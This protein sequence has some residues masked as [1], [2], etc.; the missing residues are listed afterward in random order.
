MLLPAVFDTQRWRAS[1][2]WLLYNLLRAIQFNVHAVQFFH[3]VQLTK[4]SLLKWAWFGKSGRGH[5]KFFRALR[6]HSF[7]KNPLLK[8]L[9]PPLIP[10]RMVLILEKKSR[11]DGV[12]TPNY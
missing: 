8:F 11:G 2:V 4:A 12:D 5:P 7:K 1:P 6:A 10:V 3:L 9:D